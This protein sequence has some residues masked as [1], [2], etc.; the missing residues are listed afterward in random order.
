MYVVPK[1]IPAVNNNMIN[2]YYYYNDYR[3][4]EAKDIII[5]LLMIHTQP[6]SDVAVAATRG[7]SASCKAV[8]DPSLCRKDATSNG[9][10]SVTDN[11]L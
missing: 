1:V 2:N 3:M 11:V 7:I 9:S 6:E 10:S 8:R 4:H 5:M